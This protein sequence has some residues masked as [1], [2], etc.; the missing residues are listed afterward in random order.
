MHHKKEERVM[1]KG[2]VPGKSEDA[3]TQSG[4]GLKRRDLLLSGSSLLAASVLAGAGLT[5]SAQ[6]QQPPPL[7]SS[8]R[9]TSAIKTSFCRRCTVS[10]SSSVTYTTSTRWKT[11]RTPPT[12]R[13]C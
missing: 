1:S 3:R 4:G 13:S 6:A 12:R 11:R 5:T 8:A 7:A 9:I 10:T 2:Q